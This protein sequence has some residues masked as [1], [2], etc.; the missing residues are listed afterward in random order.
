MRATAEA[1]LLVTRAA[2]TRRT[3]HRALQQHIPVSIQ[4]T[5][6]EMHAAIHFN[7]QACRGTGKVCDEATDDQLPAERDTELAAAQL[8]PELLL[9]ERGLVACGEREAEARADAAG[10]D[11]A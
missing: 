9:R 1:M 2:E 8:S 10:R 7:D 4:V 11:A 5:A 6:C 3:R